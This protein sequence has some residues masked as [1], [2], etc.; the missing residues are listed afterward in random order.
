MHLEIKRKSQKNLCPQV[1]IF[2][3][4]YIYIYT[5]SQF[6]DIENLVSVSKK[7]FSKICQILHYLEGQNFPKLFCS[8][9][10]QNFVE[11]KNIYWITI[12]YTC[13][14]VFGSTYVV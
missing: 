2:G 14:G 1:S 9:K 4:I 13:I 12:Q 10:R 11:I 7:T 8:K 5:F 3:P 6:W